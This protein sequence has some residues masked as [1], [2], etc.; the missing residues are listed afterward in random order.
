[1]TETRSLHRKLAEVY[2]EVERIPK[3]G[4]A[5]A[6]MGG[7][8]FVQVGDAADPIRA[9]L[10][11]RSLTM[12]PS[13]IDVT[14][15]TEHEDSRQRTVTTIDVRVTWIVTDGETGETAT[16]TSMGC[17]SDRGDKYVPKALSNAMKYAILLGFLMPTGDD[18]ELTDSSDRQARR[19]RSAPAG[20]E[21]PPG[22]PRSTPPGPPDPGPKE[23]LLGVLTKAGTVKPGGAEGYKLEARQSPD[24]MSLGFRLEVDGDRAIPQVLLEGQLAADVVDAT[25]GKPESLAGQWAKVRGQLFTVSQAGRTTFYRLRVS[26]IETRE[27]ALPAPEPTPEAPSQPLFDAETEAQLDRAAEARVPAHAA[28]P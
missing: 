27:W 26:S 3:R 2:A 28:L 24:G 20:L 5:P 18:P 1:M 10:A 8:E 4:R 16:I 6:E 9:A 23:E 19:P 13:A 12:L 7:F 21:P 11:K 22:G 15:Q 25:G 14:G 17:G